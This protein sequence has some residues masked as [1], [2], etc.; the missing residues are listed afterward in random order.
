VSIDHTTDR[1][2]AALLDEDA[3][4]LYENAPCGYF[5]ATDEG[6]L[7]KANATFLTMT[8]YER[9][10]LLARMRL[11]DMLTIGSRILFETHLRPLLRMQGFLR[12]IAMDLVCADG[13][14]LPVLLNA[15]ERRSPATGVAVLRAMVIDITERRMYERE[16]LL[17]RVK[18]ERASRARSEMI[19]TVSHDVRAPLGAALTAAA[20][21]ETTAPNAKQERYI[22]IIKSSVDQAVTLMNSILDL[23][24]LDGGRAVLHEKPFELR[25]L[26]EEV[27]NTS[28]LAAAEKPHLAVRH[29][30][31]GAVPDRLIGDRAKLGQVLTNLLTNAVKFTGQGTVSLVVYAREVSPAAATV[32][33]VVSDTGIGIPADRLPHIFEEF[34]QASDDIAETYGGSG[35]GLAITRK[36][37]RLYGSE[38][39]VTSTVGQGTTFSFTLQLARAES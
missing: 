25:A 27:G 30:V 7:V 22:K 21:L 12:E 33:C 38:L 19:A 23:S 28:A 16:L 31:D 26:I 6:I 10:R 2:Y 29:T 37:L 5:S 36:L 9:E 1:L 8:G 20:M 11:F 39:H 24:A 18:A 32:E 15:T 14:H 35:L 13:R 4:D 17:A 3:T 34:T